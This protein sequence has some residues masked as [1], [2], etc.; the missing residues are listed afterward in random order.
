MARS[1]EL[2]ASILVYP[3]EKVA[4]A[5]GTSPQSYPFHGCDPL[6]EQ[7]AGALQMRQGLHWEKLNQNLEVLFVVGLHHSAA[8]TNFAVLPPAEYRLI[9]VL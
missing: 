1:Q 9:V 6:V 8:A 4:L 2:G 5:D 3:V 7:Y